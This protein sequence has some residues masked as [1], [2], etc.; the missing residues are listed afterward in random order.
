MQ[1]LIERGGTVRCVYSEKIDVSSLGTA[2]IRRASHVEP[3][4]SGQWL[5]DLSPLAGPVLG[6][7]PLRSQALA[8]EQ[9]WL[10]AN[11]LCDYQV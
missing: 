3:D 10:E 9:A 6:P 5:A 4:Q 1:L 7:F 8:A 2:T 11:W